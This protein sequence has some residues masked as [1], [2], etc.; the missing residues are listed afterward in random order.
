M[1]D[2]RSLTDELTRR[3]VPPAALRG[4]SA[5]TLY[6]MLTNLGGVRTFSAAPAPGPARSQDPLV[7]SVVRPGGLLARL[8]PDL[9]RR[10]RGTA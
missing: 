4:L 1:D 3:G 10:L 8:R 6:Q 5:G 9:A 7:R 2:V